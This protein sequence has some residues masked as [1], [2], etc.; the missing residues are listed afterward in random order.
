MKISITL[1]S[2][3]QRLQVFFYELTKVLL[4][5]ISWL[6][7]FASL[8]YPLIKIWTGIIDKK[9]TVL[10]AISY[11]FIGVGCFY[12]SISLDKILKTLENK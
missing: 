2:I 7:G 1:S 9:F 3:N 10:N 8:W 6:L 11:I 4:R 5:V 12:F